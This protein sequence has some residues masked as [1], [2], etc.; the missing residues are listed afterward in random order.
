[1][2]NRLLL[3]NLGLAST[4]VLACDGHGDGQTQADSHQPID[5]T[6]S[7]EADD[8]WFTPEN[9]VIA[10]DETVKFEATNTGTFN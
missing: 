9:L 3:A 7:L 4:T 10:L 8:M 6:A 1:L 5:R 2:R